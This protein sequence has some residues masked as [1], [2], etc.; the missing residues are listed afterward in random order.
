MKKMADIL[1]TSI[2][3]FA[4]WDEDYIDPDSSLKALEGFASELSE[5]T[6]E[7]IKVLAEVAAE[8]AIKAREANSPKEWVEFYENV[9]ENLGLSDRL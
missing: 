2:G 8:N 6:D 9:I 1:L 5:C 7:E 3:Y 4:I